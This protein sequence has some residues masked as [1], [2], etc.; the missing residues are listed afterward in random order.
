[1]ES[2][3]RMSKANR[4]SVSSNVWAEECAI[5]ESVWA[6]GRNEGESRSDLDAVN[7]EGISDGDVN[8]E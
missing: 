3:W 1:M 2:K 5:C 4:S 6:W 7:G 8:E